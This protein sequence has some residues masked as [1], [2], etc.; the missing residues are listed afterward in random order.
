MTLTH[1]NDQGYGQMV[2]V[3]DKKES[4]REAIAHASISMSAE[5]YDAIVHQRIQKG[6]AL[7]VAQVAGIQAAKLTSMLIPMTHPLALTKV[8]LS[9]SFDEKNHR[10]D[11]QSL[12]RCLGVTGVEMEALTAASTCALTIYDMAK[13]L[14]KSMCISDIYLVKKTGGK[15]GEYLR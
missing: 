8:D 4:L 12:V 9:Y 1:L 14:D 5:A 3:S 7:A 2:D 13:A 11:I 6:D 10:I 15:S